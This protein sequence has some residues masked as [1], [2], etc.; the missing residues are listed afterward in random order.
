V[1]IL[2]RLDALFEDRPARQVVATS[3]GLVVVVGTVDHLIGHGISLSIF[4]LAPIGL[5][6]WYAGTRAGILLA[7]VSAVTWLLVD[8]TPTA[9]AAI[10]V[11]NAV[12]G[13][14]VFLIV[15][16][17]LAALRTHRSA[18][19]Q[20]ARLDGLTGVM[21]ARTFREVAGLHFEL[22]RRH[23]DTISLGYIDLDHLRRI[24]DASGHSEGDRLLQ[25][26][27]AVLRARL[28]GTDVVGRLGGD[29][30]AVLL[31]K[32]GY[33][34][35]K[36]VFDAIHQQLGQLARDRGWP[37]G[38]SIGVAVF[39]TAPPSADEALRYADAL[40]SRIKQAGRDDVHYQE[41]WV[42]GEG[43]RPA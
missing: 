4:Y 9:H 14:G 38:F 20:L 6:A 10:P 29:E 7:V 12:A 41:Y 22:A 33:P 1:A 31:P 13:L 16:W 8:D 2:R 3:L 23:R 35:A 28:R 18:M 37:I 27:G 25:A 43:G 26:V 24:N 39:R 21:N 42:S 36:T 19:A 5:A 40:V 17:L 30:F 11:W 34:G 32:T 15:A